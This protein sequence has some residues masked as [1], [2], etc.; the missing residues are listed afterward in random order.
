MLGYGIAVVLFN[1]FWMMQDYFLENNF[2][3]KYNFKE[4]GWLA[5]LFWI[6]LISGIA[7]IIYYLFN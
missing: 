2:L 3:D 7:A 4:F 6:Y 1:L 5:I